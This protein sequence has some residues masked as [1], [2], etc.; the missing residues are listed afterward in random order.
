MKALRTSSVRSLV[1]LHLPLWDC[2]EYNS[3]GMI[4]HCTS[5][6]QNLCRNLLIPAEMF[7][8]WAGKGRGIVFTIPVLDSFRRPLVFFEISSRNGFV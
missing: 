6:W 8:C 1:D 3:R 2:A 4:G 7:W 5:H